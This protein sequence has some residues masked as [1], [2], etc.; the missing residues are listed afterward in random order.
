MLI[1]SSPEPKR[2]TSLIDHPSHPTREYVYGDGFEEHEVRPGSSNKRRHSTTVEED[3]SV[4]KRRVG[5]GEPRG[6]LT[7]QQRA[8]ARKSSLD[9]SFDD[10]ASN[11]STKQHRGSFFGEPASVVDDL[12]ASSHRKTSKPDRISRDKEDP[13]NRGSFFDVGD[14]GST[15]AHETSR[16]QYSTSFDKSDQLENSSRRS[17]LLD[18]PPTSARKISNTS[19]VKPDKPNRGSFFSTSET[20]MDSYLQDLEDVEAASALRK[21]NKSRRNTSLGK[22]QAS[23]AYKTSKPDQDSD[24]RTLAALLHWTREAK[25][26]PRAILW[27]SARLMYHLSPLDRRL[28]R[29]S[30][31]GQPRSSVLL[32]TIPRSSSMS[33]PFKV[34]DAPFRDGRLDTPFDREEDDDKEPELRGLADR[35]AKIEE[36]LT[37]IA[38]SLSKKQSKGASEHTEDFSTEVL[39]KKTSR[40]EREADQAVQKAKIYNIDPEDISTKK[41]PGLIADEV[42]LTYLYDYLTCMLTYLHA[43]LAYMLTYLHG[44]IYS[45]LHGSLY[46]YLYGYLSCTANSMSY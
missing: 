7:I 41:A 45:Y 40:R 8:E 5:Q 20:V 23:S 13:S 38:A 31:T 25:T 24:C 16:P 39:P 44:Y 17:F 22:D 12:E 21:S 42:L 18:G 32:S 15:S 26:Y 29:S 30:V 14:I 36:L 19:L 34:T 6:I 11:K 37:P 27:A 43:H 1:L 10:I 4:K 33:S 2:T 9:N 28:E 46:D 3:D 35:L